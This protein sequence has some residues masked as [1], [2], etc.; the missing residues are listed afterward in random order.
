MNLP[1]PKDIE[2]KKYYDLNEWGF[3]LTNTEA[4][5]ENQNILEKI[6]NDFAQNFNLAPSVVKDAFN[7]EYI[8]IRTTEDIL[9]LYNLAGSDDVERLYV[10]INMK[11][12]KELFR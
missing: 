10:N 9:I 2:F 7:V 6:A 1:E 3:D 4:S 5:Q 8:S 11:Y 12:F